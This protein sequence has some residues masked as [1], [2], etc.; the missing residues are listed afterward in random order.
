MT[1]H[2]RGRGERRGDRR[3]PR[4]CQ[5]FIPAGAGN[6]SPAPI[7]GRCSGTVHPR[8]RGERRGR[9]WPCHSPGSSPRARGT[10]RSRIAGSP[11]GTVHPRGRGERATAEAS[12]RIASPGSSPRAR[13]TRAVTSAILG[14]MIGS[15]PRARGTRRCGYRRADPVRFIPAGAGNAVVRLAVVLLNLRFI[16]AGAGN[17]HRDHLRAARGSVHPRGRGERLHVPGMPARRRRFI[18]AGAGNAPGARAALSRQL[19]PVHPRGRGERRSSIP[20]G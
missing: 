8:G 19:T 3:S 6:A 7:L 15:S 12:P 16:P 13:G 11:D 14:C 5:R 4:G 20:G 1:V 9:R 2:P 17:A 18:P 10:R